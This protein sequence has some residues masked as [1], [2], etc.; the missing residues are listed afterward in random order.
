VLD[1]YLAHHQH[2][3]NHHGLDNV[4]PFPSEQSSCRD[5]TI[6]K[7]ERLGGLLNFYQHAA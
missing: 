3:R 1:E 6:R 7:S 4:I 2:E 5:G